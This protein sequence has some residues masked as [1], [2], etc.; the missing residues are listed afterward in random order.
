MW[1]DVVD[2]RDFYETQ[3]GRIARQFVG[4]AIRRHWPDLT[5]Q[6]LMGFGYPV[7]YLQ[8][9]LGEAERV[10]AFMPASRGVMRWAEEGPN[11]A[12]LVEETDLPLPDYSVDRVLFVHGLEYTL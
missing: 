8:Q 2:F 9:F 5:G 10:I 4:D 12:C 7:P 11:R 3:R 1:T 6:R